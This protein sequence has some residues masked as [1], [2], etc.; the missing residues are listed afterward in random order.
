MFPEPDDQVSWK[1]A[2]SGALHV[3]GFKTNVMRSRVQSYTHGSYDKD[4]PRDPKKFVGK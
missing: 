2:P 1:W 3:I 4:A